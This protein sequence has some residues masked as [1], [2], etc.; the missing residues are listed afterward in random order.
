[1]K[2][3]NNKYVRIGALATTLFTAS[4]QE[5]CMP[6]LN[7]A[8][9]SR[10]TV[11]ALNIGEGADTYVNEKTGESGTKYKRPDVFFVPGYGY[12]GYYGYGFGSP[13]NCGSNGCR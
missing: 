6:S 12:Y 5:A 11:R 7:M 2:I 8:R 3:I 4:L 1:M 13:S 9:D 10:G